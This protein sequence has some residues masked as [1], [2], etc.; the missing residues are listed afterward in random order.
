MTLGATVV[1]ILAERT[2]HA[3]CGNVRIRAKKS[4]RT[5]GLGTLN[6][7]TTSLSHQEA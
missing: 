2:E 7:A 4:G 3:A 6:C 1:R 5:D